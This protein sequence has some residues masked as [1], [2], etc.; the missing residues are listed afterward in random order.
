MA[1]RVRRMVSSGAM[2]GGVAAML[3]GVPS[4]WAGD[5]GTGQVF[6]RG[7]WA[8]LGND[9]GGEVFTDTAAGLGAAAAN[10]GDSGYAV[11]AGLDLTLMG[12][13]E[14]SQFP[15]DV[16]VLGEIFV[17]YSEYSRQRVVQTAS[18]LLA[19][20][21]ILSEPALTKISVSELAVSVAPKVRFNSKGSLR[22]W[23]VPVG[24]AFLVNSPPSNNATYLDLGLQFGGGIELKLTDA[25]SVGGDLR[26]VYAFERSDTETSYLSAGGYLGI[27]F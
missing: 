23:L 9:R 4:A 1:R 20:D 26:Y 3:C 14:M 19:A 22:P 10:D 2:V 8:Q 27:N 7:A 16:C 13:D 25:L 21:G 11:G 18:A 24:V 12:P 15:G 6:F 17:E 5:G